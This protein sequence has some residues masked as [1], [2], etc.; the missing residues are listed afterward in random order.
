MSDGSKSWRP[1]LGGGRG[2]LP[3]GNP[4]RPNAPA[5]PDLGKRVSPTIRHDK[6]SGRTYHETMVKQ[7]VAGVNIDID[8]DGGV[9]LDHDELAK[10]LETGNID[11][12]IVRIKDAVGGAKLQYQQ[13]PAADFRWNG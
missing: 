1:P 9:F 13:R 10:L 8:R 3:G 7:T 12:L 4:P 2:R 6:S 5:T 11:D